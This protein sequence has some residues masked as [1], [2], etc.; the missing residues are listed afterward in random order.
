MNR[1]RESRRALIELAE[2]RIEYDP[3]SDVLYI[4]FA[5]DS[6]EASEEELI[7]D[8]VVARLRE[9]VLVGLTVL[10]FSRRIQREIL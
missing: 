9:G 1:E 3:Q 5:P 10:D 4:D 8:D 2:V 7:G 6:E